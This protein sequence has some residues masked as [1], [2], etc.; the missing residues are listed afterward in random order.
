MHI[1]PKQAARVLLALAARVAAY[2]GL[3]VGLTA[4]PA[5]GT[6]LWCIAGALLVILLRWK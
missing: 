4:S 3:G 6:G 2:A 5:A 1:R